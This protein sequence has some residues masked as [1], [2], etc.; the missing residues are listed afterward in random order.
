MTATVSDLAAAGQAIRQ[1]Q[2]E[3]HQVY[4]DTAVQLGTRRREQAAAAPE[5][6]PGQSTAQAQ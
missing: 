2:L 1:A 4:R 3:A 5:A 6:Q